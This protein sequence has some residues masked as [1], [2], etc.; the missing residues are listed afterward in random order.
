MVVDGA[1]NEIGR[2]L[3]CVSDMGIGWH[4]GRILSVAS[5]D[6][7][8]DF[9]PRGLSCGFVKVNRPLTPGTGLQLKDRRRHIKVTVVEDIRPDR[10]AR[11]PIE[12]ML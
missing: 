7:P 11:R 9:V 3:T 12:E 10:T 8:Q 1:G 6:Q 4:A 5:P 2:V